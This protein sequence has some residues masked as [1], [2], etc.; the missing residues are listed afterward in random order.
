MQLVS[1]PYTSLQPTSRSSRS[2]AIISAALPPSLPELPLGLS[3]LPHEL[4]LGKIVITMAYAFSAGILFFDTVSNAQGDY[5]L[6][7]K[8]WR[9]I[10]IP[11]YFAARAFGFIFCITLIFNQ[12]SPSLSRCT[13]DQMPAG[14][15]GAIEVLTQI[16]EYA[17]SSGLE[18][19]ADC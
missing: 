4:A 13:W 9:S 11:A 19:R 7:R 15:F 8:A 1:L 10:D 2:A 17:C 14:F 3:G 5:R 12:F 18:V 16:S 6:C